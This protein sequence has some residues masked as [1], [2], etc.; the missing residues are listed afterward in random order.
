MAKNVT[1]ETK[2][3]LKKSY[4]HGDVWSFRLVI[5]VSSK[6]AFYKVGDVLKVKY[7]VTY[8]CYDHKDRWVDYW[9]IGK[10][11]PKPDNWKEI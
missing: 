11:I 10:E 1:A 8:G 4:P 5:R 9:D 6:D 7:F 3:R 2:E